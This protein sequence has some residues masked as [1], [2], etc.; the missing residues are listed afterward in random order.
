MSSEVRGENFVITS[1]QYNA[2]VFDQAGPYCLLTVT[3]GARNR[4]DSS[5][6]MQVTIAAK[7]ITALA[8]WVKLVEAPARGNQND[9]QDLYFH[10]ENSANGDRYMAYYGQLRAEGKS[11]AEAIEGTLE[12]FSIKGQDWYQSRLDH[13]AT[14][15]WLKGKS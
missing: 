5:A 10:L 15:G 12:K 11:H 9:L 3:H 8:D 6:R 7:D 2:V 14:S 13:R 4:H 1:D